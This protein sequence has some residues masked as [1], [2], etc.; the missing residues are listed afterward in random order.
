MRKWNK[1]IALLVAGLAVAGALYYF[2]PYQKSNSKSTISTSTTQTEWTST[3]LSGFNAS[4]QESFHIPQNGTLVLYVKYWYYNPNSTLSLNFTLGKAIDQI[5]GSEGL[6]ATADA[7]GNFTI[8]SNAA[9]IIFGGP[10]NLSEG[11]LVVYRIHPIAGDGTYEF[12]MGITYPSMEGCETYFTIV[13]GN[14]LP[15]Y[16]YQGGC[17]ATISSH[18]PLNSEG[19]VDG[20]I[21]AEV[22]E[23]SSE[24]ASTST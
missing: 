20:F 1:I 2:V 12:N 16:G 14:G 9:S 11:T 7:A 13:I 22:T 24:T 5:T 23:A 8:S 19:F 4:D 10:D 6:E 3:F 17:T 18:Y 15:N 21:I